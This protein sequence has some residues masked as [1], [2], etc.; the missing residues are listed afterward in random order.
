MIFSR[1]R[2]SGMKIHAG[3][4]ALAARAATALARL[5]VDAQP[6][7]GRSN[8]S[9]RFTAIATTRSLKESVGEFAASFLIHRSSIPSALPRE[10]A[11]RR[12]V[13]PTSWPTRG[14]SC[15][16]NSSR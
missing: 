14:S 7:A 4:P 3:S 12:G 1:S 11:G 13:K 2:S 10:G 5:P 15:S 16:G 8:S 6:T 9:A